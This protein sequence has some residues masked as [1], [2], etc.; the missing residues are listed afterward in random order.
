MR[1]KITSHKIVDCQCISFI[2]WHSLC[3]FNYFRCSSKNKTFSGEGLAEGHIARLCYIL[4]VAHL[5]MRGKFSSDRVWSRSRWRWDS[6]CVC[7]IYFGAHLEKEARSP[8]KTQFP[9]QVSLDMNS[10]FSVLFAHQEIRGMIS[11]DKTVSWAG[12]AGGDKACVCSV[13]F[14]S[15]LI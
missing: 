10:V 11:S 6:L 7:L 9:E 15:L 5:E 4:F 2:R 12:P 14:S 3:V 1:G 8:T 13:L